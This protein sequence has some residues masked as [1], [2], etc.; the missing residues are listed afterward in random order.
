MK[1]ISAS[2]CLAT[3]NGAKYLKEQLDSL[4]YQTFMPDEIVVSDDNSTDETPIILK[5]FQ[6]QYP[7]LFRVFLHNNRIGFIRNFERCL[8]EARWGSRRPLRSR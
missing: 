8:K 7:H 6:S 5:Q 2:V 3:F 1:K 4:L